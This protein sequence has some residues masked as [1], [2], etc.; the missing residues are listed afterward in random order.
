MENIPVSF[1]SEGKN[2]SGT[3]TAVHGAGTQ[4]YYLMI[5]K[6]YNGRLRLSELY[7]WQFDPTPKT[8]SFKD[9]SDFFGDVVTA[10]YQ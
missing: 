1:E 3:L 6:Y 10:W 8:Q 4:T 7:G 5:D 9:L 2:Y